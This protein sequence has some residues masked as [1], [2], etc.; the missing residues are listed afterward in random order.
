[1]SLA[2]AL[3]SPIFALSDEA[4]FWLSRDQGGLTAG[5]F[6]EELPRELSAEDRHRARFAS[7]TLH[8]LRL[9]KDR[10]SIAEL[11]R[12]VLDRTAY[13]A[14]LV[15]EY[16]G[17]RKLANL[18]KLL[19]QARSMDRSGV[20]TL[21]DF[22][23]QLSEFVARQSDEALAATSAAT[24]NVV[25]LMSIHASK[26]LEFPVVVVADL[27]RKSRAS[28]VAAVFDPTL[29]P[30]V[31]HPAGKGCCGLKLHKCVEELEDAAEM[32]RLLYVA[33]TRAA[34]YLILSS[35]IE[36]L[37]KPAGDWTR[38]VAERFDLQTG[39]PTF[40]PTPDSP[41]PRVRVTTTEP[42]APRDG[43]GKQE[44]LDL[45]EVVSAAQQLAKQGGGLVPPTVAP[46]GPRTGARRG[47]SFSRLKPKLVRA[48]SPAD[49]DDVG[50]ET[51]PTLIDGR[52]LGTLVH[53]V[54][55]A[56]DFS[57]PGDVARSVR[58]RAGRHALE[59]SAE[60]EVAVEMLKRFVTSPRALALG[61]AKC[62]ERELPFMLAWP[63]G[64]SAV[65]SQYLE[66]V[67]DCLYQDTA[68]AWH[69]L[70]YKTDDVAPRQIVDAASR[71]RLQLHMYAWAAEEVLGQRPASVAL[72]F[73]RPGIEHAFDWNEAARRSTIDELELALAAVQEE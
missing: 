53:E 33:T 50:L 39:Q 47:Y 65:G 13:D 18:H 10:L 71:Y 23:G 3:R 15:A 63:P 25:R 69:L 70:D 1:L 41:L 37:D 45:D 19:E 44:R 59:Q 22:I 42:P 66:G 7:S 17:Q 35:G 9:A 40:E 32:A 48:R 6:R 61:R 26:G 11:L 4:L 14:T 8:D 31:K 16:M 54:L 60:V 12:E 20:F 36:S 27:E 72:H 2:G 56:W 38:L 64:R 68:G 51:V 49:A 24:A 43:G 58:S 62:I 67:I 52:G 5:L 73:L 34:D 21:T 46:I 30:L 29:G 57:R 28:N 55:A